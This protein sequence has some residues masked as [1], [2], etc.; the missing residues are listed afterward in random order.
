MSVQLVW[1]V[2]GISFWSCWAM[3]LGGTNYK[4]RISGPTSIFIVIHRR[5]ILM[6]PVAIMIL[7]LRSISWS[8]P[9][10]IS[11]FVLK[12]DIGIGIR[13][14]KSIDRK[15]TFQA[16]TEKCRQRS[17][18][19]GRGASVQLR[20]NLVGWTRF[21]CSLLLFNACSYSKNDDTFVPG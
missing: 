21:I 12:A 3:L 4:L 14:L 18:V 20:T 8:P 9:P 5:V 15:L 16:H 2:L 13:L 10:S 17:I 1:A 19:S 11:W 6:I 7:Q